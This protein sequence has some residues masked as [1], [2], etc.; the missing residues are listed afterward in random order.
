MEYTPIAIA[1]PPRRRGAEV[2]HTAQSLSKVTET[3]T[4][5]AAAVFAELRYAKL[6]YSDEPTYAS[7]NES[8]ALQKQ[9]SMT[10]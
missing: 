1:P 8:R 6:A 10:N 2:R 7:K 4:A 3:T 5:A 9:L